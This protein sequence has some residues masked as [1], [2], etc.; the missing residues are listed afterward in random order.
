[1]RSKI[2]IPL[3]TLSLLLSACGGI[4]E[5]EIEANDVNN[6]AEEL[7]D[8]YEWKAAG[9]SFRHPD[10]ENVL[11]LSNSTLFINK[12][13]QIPESEETAFWTTVNIYKGETVSER[14]T[15]YSSELEYSS[16]EEKIAEKTFIK[17]S[18]YQEFGD[19]TVIRY[20]LESQKGVF[21][22]KVG[23]NEEALAQMI[24]ETLEI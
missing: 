7:T 24:L 14:L 21:E 8:F 13:E 4:W 6:L 5:K 23:Q 3:L 1:M 9:I 12:S 16:M 11:R 18:F 10:T 2:L 19:K 20:L 15:T 22:L 17:V